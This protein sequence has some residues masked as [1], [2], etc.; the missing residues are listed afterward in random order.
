MNFVEKF[1]H[2]IAVWLLGFY[3]AWNQ[4]FIVEFFGLPKLQ[5]GDPVYEVITLLYG[6][7]NVIILYIILF[8]IIKPTYW[9]GSHVNA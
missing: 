9:V 5:T 6:L 7:G 3:L 4:I 8:L 2:V 1:I